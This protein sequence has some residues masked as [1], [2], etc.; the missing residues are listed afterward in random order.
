MLP[1]RA[2]EL[3]KGS[4]SGLPGRAGEMEGVNREA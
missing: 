1:G 4:V 2:G 3:G